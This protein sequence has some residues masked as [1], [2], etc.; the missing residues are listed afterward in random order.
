LHVTSSPD[1]GSR[2]EILLPCVQEP[3][4]NVVTI[5][6]SVSNAGHRL[7]IG[8][9]LMIEDEEI[10]RVPVA[11]MLRK[12][13]F[14]VIEAGD[15][16]TG[17]RLFRDNA[18]NIDVVLLDVTMPGMSAKQIV[19]ELRSSRPDVKVILTSAFTLEKAVSQI[20]GAHQW[21]Y[22]RKPYQLSDVT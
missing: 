20:G 22:I 7:A 3:A 14:S 8:T 13:G 9:G 21:A 15:G 1:H 11:K 18:S 10:L 12:S 2:F 16:T 5:S 19:E 17:A 4:R 6:A